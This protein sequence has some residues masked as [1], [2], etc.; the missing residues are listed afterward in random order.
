MSGIGGQGILL[1]TR[2]VG[3]AAARAG[4]Q[5]LHFGRYGG[6]I[7][8]TECECTLLISNS[9]SPVDELPVTARASFAI[10]MHPA[11]R[12]RVSGRLLAGGTLLYNSSLIEPFAPTDGIRVVPVAADAAAESLG[13]RVGASLYA[14]AYLMTLA[15]LFDADALVAGLPDL[16]PPYRHHTIPKN[17][18]IIHAGALAAGE[19]GAISAV[20]RGAGATAV[21][22]V[23]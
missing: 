2:L 7:R 14:I 17:A 4:K 8:G 20:A 22:G 5:C 10:A 3:H 19:V 18:E 6:E 21:G 16:L 23:R 15:G 9:A 12:E 11:Y 1:A 13:A